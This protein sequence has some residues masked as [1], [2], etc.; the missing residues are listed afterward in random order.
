MEVD[1][2]GIATTDPS[3]RLILSALAV[4]MLRSASPRL[5]GAQYAISDGGFTPRFAFFDGGFA[6]R[7]P[8]KSRLRRKK[9]APIACRTRSCS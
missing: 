4:S 6:P 1:L 9:T 7:R 8:E 3:P 2:V 5:H